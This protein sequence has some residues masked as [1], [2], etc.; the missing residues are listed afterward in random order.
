MTKTC[1]KCGTTLDASAFPKHKKGAGGIY[2]WCRVCTGAYAK[3]YRQKAENKEAQR[4]YMMEYRKKNPE[5]KKEK[6]DRSRLYN[7]TPERKEKLRQRMSD[8]TVYTKTRQWFRD[9][10]RKRKTSDPNYRLATLL[11][12]RVYRAIRRGSGTKM[13]GS[14]ELLGCSIAELMT[15]LE[16]RFL[17]GMTW[18]NHT[19]Q[20][21]HIDHIRPCASFD[22]TDIEQ[23]KACFHYTNLQPLWAKDN[24][25]KGAKT[26]ATSQ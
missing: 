4:L 12:G 21:W 20:G 14:V 3:A 1:T 15:Y 26:Y 23:Q 16:A 11:R 10:N 9:Y 25:A 22:L 7:S 19:I 13:K 5:D 8:P 18:Q 17:P 6:S 2:S 24:I